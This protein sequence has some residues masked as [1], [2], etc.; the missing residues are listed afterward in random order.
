M[1]KPALAASPLAAAIDRAATAA[2]VPPASLEVAPLFGQCPPLE[3]MDPAPLAR[4]AAC[5]RL[6]L[7]TNAI[8]RVAGLGGMPRLTS[9]SLGRNALRRLDGVEAATGLQELWV[10]YNQLDK[11]VCGGG[12]EAG[13]WWKV[14]PATAAPLPLPFRP[15]SPPPKSCPTCAPCS[16]P[17]TGSPPGPRWSAWEG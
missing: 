9:L 1:S 13:G 15:P 11:L 6:S 4:L 14:G 3:T 2:G 12:G 17:T 7:S 8:D 10:S 16:P 5:T